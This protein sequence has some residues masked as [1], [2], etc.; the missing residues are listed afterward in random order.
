MLVS[1]DAGSGRTELLRMLAVAAARRAN[2]PATVLAEGFRDGRFVGWG[3]DGPPAAEVMRVVVD[4][5]DRAPDGLWADLVLGMGSRVA[6]DW[7]LLLVLALDGP[8]RSGRRR[9]RRVGTVRGVLRRE[10]PAGRWI[11]FDELSAGPA[12][13]VLSHDVSRTVRH[14]DMLVTRLGPCSVRRARARCIAIAVVSAGP[15]VCGP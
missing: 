9:S 15:A 10:R 4:D 12:T 14:D 5:A 13:R 2:P 8:A 6:S 11:E 7:P 3:E 1:G